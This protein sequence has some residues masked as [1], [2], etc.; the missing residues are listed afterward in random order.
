MELLINDLATI[1]EKKEVS[2]VRH[3]SGAFPIEASR[4]GNAFLTV[5]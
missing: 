1:P 4:Q 2:S 3:T 5:T